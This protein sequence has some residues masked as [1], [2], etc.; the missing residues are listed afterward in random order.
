MRTKDPCWSVGTIYA[1][2]ELLGVSIV[3]SGLDEVLQVVSEPILVVSR[4]C[5]GWGFV[6]LAHGAYGL[7]VVTCNDI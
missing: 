3:G 1:P 6:Y 5:V 7:G 2:R 4:T